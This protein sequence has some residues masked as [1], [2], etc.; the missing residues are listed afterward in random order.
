MTTTTK[1]D[2]AAYIAAMEAAKI[3]DSRIHASLSRQWDWGYEGSDPLLDAIE[4]AGAPFCDFPAGDPHPAGPAAHIVGAHMHAGEDCVRILLCEDC[5]TACVDSHEGADT[6]D[7]NCE[8]CWVRPLSEQ[9]R[10]YG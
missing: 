3:T 8:S 4:T 7:P 5:Y 9:A 2:I 1:N 10:K 6:T